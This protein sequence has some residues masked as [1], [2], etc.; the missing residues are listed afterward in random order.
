LGLGQEQFV[1]QEHAIRFAPEGIVLVGKDKPDYRV[2]RYDPEA[3]EKMGNL[4]DLN[5]ERGSADAVYDF[6]EQACAVRWLY[7]TPTGNV[8]PQR[9]TLAITPPELRRR[10]SLELRNVSRLLYAPGFSLWK[11]GS[12]ESNEWWE[13]VWPGAG[14][15]GGIRHNLMLLYSMRWHNGGRPFLGNHSLEAF[16]HRFCAAGWEE[17]LANAQD[18][19]EREAILASKA[20]IFEADRPEF[21]AQGYPVKFE[22]QLCYTNPALVEQVAKDARAYFAGETVYGHWWKL[23]NP[24]VIEPMDSAQFCQCENC[25][26]WVDKSQVRSGFASGI[27]SDY[28]FQFVNAVAREVHKTNPGA[29]FL[30]LAYMTHT[31]VPERVRLDPAIHVQFCWAS[32][33]TGFMFPSG[34]TEMARQTKML[35]AWVEEA[36]ESE[37]DLSLWFYNT[38]PTESYDNLGVNGFPGAFA[39]AFAEQIK[40][41]H[42][43]GFR[44]IYH[45]GW[46]EEVE[47]YIGFKLMYDVNQDVEALIDEYFRGM[48]GPAAA[49]MKQMY[50]EMEDA[51]SNPAHRPKT[52]VGTQEL[53]WKHLGSPERMARWHKLFEQA[54]ALAGGERERKNLELFDKAYWSYMRAGADKYTARMTAPLQSA[55]IPRVPEAGGDCTKVDWAQ[56]S[57]PV[58]HF[59]RQDSDHPAR[60]NMELLLAH[61]NE[62]LYMKYTDP[63][64]EVGRLAPGHWNDTLE[65]FAANSRALPFRQFIL[66]TGSENPLRI[67]LQGEVNWR[68]GI[69]LTEHH[70][71]YSNHCPDEET[72]EMRVAIPL[73]ELVP[74]GQPL[75]AGGVFYMNVVRVSPPG[76]Y[77]KEEEAGAGFSV[78]TLASYC[79]LAEMDRLAEFTL[80]P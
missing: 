50:L 17:R 14:T 7:P 20:K 77:L 62:Y 64:G 42:K 49:P 59:C 2:L 30:T 28:H 46:G 74:P 40:F 16:Y 51:W 21:F 34:D 78:S 8:I 36:K 3:P 66:Y 75:Q 4:P 19:K 37:R 23:P 33:R 25:R 70:I 13:A 56:A 41:I 10:A 60:R 63:V 53:S 43:K 31:A 79:G 57:S 1:E 72:L 27:H 71:R 52:N 15:N 69:Q 54:Q 48:Y 29:P 12:A 45:C 5:D 18:E 80:A 26:E 61:D 11:S 24:F 38:F 22:T 58:P 39:H 55:T 67:I 6:L 73:E 44:G 68:M 32:N 65:I 47:N 76:L 35:E 9:R